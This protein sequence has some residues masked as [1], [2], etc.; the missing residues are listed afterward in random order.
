MI[1]VRQIVAAF[2]FVAAARGATDAGEVLTPEGAAGEWRPLI[3]ALASK[4]PIE[5]T[6]TEQRYFPFRSGPMVLKGVLRT[7]TERGVSL[8]YTDPEPNVLIADAAGLIIRNRGGRSRE[9]SAQSKEGGAIASLLPIMRF[10]LPALFPRFTIRAS[11]TGEA[12]QFEFTPRD[13]AAAGSL[14][15]ITIAGSGTEVRHLEFRRSASQRVEIDVGS[16]RDGAVFTP[17]EQAKFF[18]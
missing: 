3:G 17:A 14:G 1:P 18:R 7:S 11:R 13:A 12:W 6:F 10:D 16:T 15:S 5:A 8:Q 9:I 2:A 4:G